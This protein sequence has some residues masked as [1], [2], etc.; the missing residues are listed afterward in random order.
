MEQ[1]FGVE[2]L[3]RGTIQ[4]P[5]GPVTFTL[6]TMKTINDRVGLKSILIQRPMDMPHSRGVDDGSRHCLAPK[7]D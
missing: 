7:A 2:G 1:G 3:L 5:K 4:P 6:I